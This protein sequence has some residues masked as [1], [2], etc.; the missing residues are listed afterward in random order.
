MDRNCGYR[1]GLSL[2]LGFFLVQRGFSGD[3]PALNK[4]SLGGSELS[5]AILLYIQDARSLQRQFGF[6]F[7]PAYRQGQQEMCQKWLKAIEQTPFALLSSSGRVDYILFDGYLRQR[8]R[9]LNAARSQYEA[10]TRCLPFVSDIAE[11]TE[12]RRLMK[13]SDPQEAAARLN[14][15]ADQLEVASRKNGAALREWSFYAS[16]IEEAL[17]D[18]YNFYHLYSPEFDWWME[19]PYVRL[20]EGL[21]KV[22]KILDDPGREEKLEGVRIGEQELRKLLSEEMIPYTPNEL[23]DIGRKELDWCLK[24]MRKV[25]AEL[26]FQKDWHEALEHVKKQSVPPGKQPE[27]IRKMAFEAVDFLDK[28][29]LLTI[30]DMARQDWHIDMLSPRQQLMNPFFSGGLVIALSYPTRTMSH[31]R[32]M[33]S[34]RGNNPHFCWATVHHELI[35]GHHLQGFMAERYN[36]HRLLFDTPFYVEGWPLYWEMK[37][38]DMGF[39]RSPEDRVGMLFWRMH[40]AARIVF[41]LSYHLGRMTSEQCVEMLVK[42]VGHEPENA[43]AEVRRSFSGG[44]PPLYQ[45]AYLLGG[46]QLRALAAEAVEGGRMELKEF[47]D[48]VLKENTMPIALLRA[49]LLELPIEYPFQNNW[50]F[51]CGGAGN[52]GDGR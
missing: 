4:V 9:Y 11:L 20:K 51:Y 50:R 42:T 37:M 18:W 7:L 15:A 30:P 5:G 48:A 24:E 13:W 1:F 44:Y 8:V 34:M 33:M 39:Y 38:W 21:E 23:I 32:K 12:S 28:N 41:S 6:N 19:E 26:G 47:H 10:L 49:K 3:L 16:E 40:R 46:L 22:R 36:Y 43:R 27:T 35:P 31:E 17:D 14:R 45:C 52:G 2:V 25:S 29:D